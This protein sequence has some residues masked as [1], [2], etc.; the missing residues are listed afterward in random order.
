MQSENV[1]HDDEN[2]MSELE[3]ITTQ[4]SDLCCEY[5]DISDKLEEIQKNRKVFTTR[6][7]ELSTKI[8][9]LM[10]CSEIDEVN[11]GNKHT[12]IKTDRKSTTSLKMNDIE[13]IV[14]SEKYRGI[15]N[16][17]KEHIFQDIK[18]TRITSF[19][20]ALKVKKTKP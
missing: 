3:C 7:K 12:I 15:G 19:K 18:D 20:P 14:N 2:E 6:Q 11:C 1:E 9:H 8:T 4:L 16:E 13:T 5:V 10:G 17:L